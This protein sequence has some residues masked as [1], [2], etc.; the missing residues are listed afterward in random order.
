MINTLNEIVSDDSTY[1][2]ALSTRGFYLFLKYWYQGY[3][4]KAEK[5]EK[6]KVILKTA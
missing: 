3:W 1:A 6:G 5:L 4:T 2:D